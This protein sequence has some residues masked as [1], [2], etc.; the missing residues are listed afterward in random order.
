MSR[1]IGAPANQL[2][3]VFVCRRTLKDT[4]K[5]QK[6]P[7]NETTN[8]N[9]ILNQHNPSRERDCHFLVSIK[10]SKKERKGTRKRISEAENVDDED[11]T[12][13]RGGSSPSEERPK[14]G[15][16][17]D[18]FFSTEAA[19]P[20]SILQRSVSPALSPSESADEH[21]SLGLSANANN[22][23]APADKVER[24]LLR[25]EGVNPN[26]SVTPRLGWP[27][28]GPGQRVE[29]F[30]VNAAGRNVEFLSQGPQRPPFIQDE[31]WKAERAWMQN[32]IAGR[33]SEKEMFQAVQPPPFMSPASRAE[34]F[35]LG[36]FTDS[37]L[38]QG[39]G[40]RPPTAL[41]RIGA[42][43][44]P[45][46]FPDIPTRSILSSFESSGNIIPRNPIATLL[47]VNTGV[48]QAQ[49]NSLMLHMQRPIRS[50]PVIAS[51]ERPNPHGGVYRLGQDNTD[52]R[53]DVQAYTYHCHFCSERNQGPPLFHFCV[54]DRILTGFRGP[55]PAGPITRPSKSQ[56]EVAA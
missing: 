4:E 28:V 43:N 1:L 56:L 54:N 13:S 52:S 26:S 38:S 29:G 47:T 22:S 11:S 49:M 48:H 45:P 23:I 39:F 7:I 42:M 9:I 55:S 18:K 24:I 20:T 21:I 19:S 30:D 2:S 53:A 8:F 31:H 17:V 25:R 12:S 32:G 6:L 14:P 37:T 27:V 44:H 15:L 33:Q 50:F 3:A 5:R 16:P 40:T 35:R 46:S 10:K 41:Q 36:R 34:L 51:P